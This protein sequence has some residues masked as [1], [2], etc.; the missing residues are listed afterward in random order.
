MASAE[1][2]RQVIVHS[3]TSLQAVDHDFIKFSIIPPVICFCDIPEEV[4]GSWYT[5]D[6]MVMFKEGALEPSSPLC[7]SAELA[8]ILNVTAPEKPILFVY[9]NGGPDHRV[10]YISVKLT[11]IA[12]FRKLNLDHLCAVKTVPCHSYRNP[13]ERIMSFLNLGLQAIALALKSTPEEM[14]AEAKKCNSMKALRSVAERI[15]GFIE[16]I[17]DS[18]SP[19][20]VILTDIAKRI[21]LKEKKFTVFSPATN[22]ELDIL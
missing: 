7:H 10:T 20:K 9:S 18:I 19:V 14:E 8:N 12:P 6:V 16:A 22:E 17:L 3:G 11:L 5:G 21:E 2:G 15:V 1:S 4:S 13:V